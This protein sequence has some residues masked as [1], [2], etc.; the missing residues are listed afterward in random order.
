MIMLNF[1][2]ELMLR[3][4]FIIILLLLSQPVFA[5]RQIFHPNPLCDDYVRLK[6]QE[7]LDRFE[8]ANYDDYMAYKAEVKQYCSEMM[9]DNQLEPASGGDGY[10]YEPQNR[11]IRSFNRSLD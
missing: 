3:F 5:Q 8:T 9:V 4:S 10:D 1:W 7:Y 2:L 6:T 11:G